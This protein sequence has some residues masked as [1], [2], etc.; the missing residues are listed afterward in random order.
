MHKFKILLLLQMISI[1]TFG[2]KVQISSID[3]SLNINHLDQ[4]GKK[5]GVWIEGS[6]SN[7][8][9]IEKH[10]KI[11]S[12]YYENKRE[13]IRIYIY[14]SHVIGIENYTNDS[15]NGMFVILNTKGIITRVLNFRDNLL[16]GTGYFFS[17]KGELIVTCEYENGDLISV[18]Y[19]NLKE[20]KNILPDELLK[21]PF[22]LIND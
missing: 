14:K 18:R 9:N 17:K 12:K 4:N 16:N 19:K 20:K 5:T 3:D 2:Q 10:A 6:V 8:R 22:I 13:G 7:F 1:L 11:I 21:T 15:L